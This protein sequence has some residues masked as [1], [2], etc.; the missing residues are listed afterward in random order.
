MLGVQEEHYAGLWRIELAN[1]RAQAVAEQEAAVARC[2]SS[3]AA[4]LGDVRAHAKNRCEQL[5][6]GFVRE[7]S[8]VKKHERELLENAEVLA[9][10]EETIGDGL[11]L[12]PSTLAGRPLA[13]ESR[14]GLRSFR[15]IAARPRSRSRMRTMKFLKAVEKAS[16]HKTVEVCSCK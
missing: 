3:A 13:Q 2:R 15:R 8:D 12:S 11:W 5:E 16:T 9:W 14:A 1:A 7:C 4:A 10:H 6:E